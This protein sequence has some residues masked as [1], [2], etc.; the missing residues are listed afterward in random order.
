MVLVNQLRYSEIGSSLDPRFFDVLPVTCEACGS[1]Y[2]LNLAL[3]EL[4]CINPHCSD[5]V[6]MRIRKICEAFGIKFFG[7]S[8]IEKWVDAEE[9]VNP[10]KLFDVY[11]GKLLGGVSAKVSDKVVPQII[12]AKTMKLWEFLANAQLPYIQTSARAILDGYSSL[13]DF[14]DD[15]EAGGVD[16]IRVKLGIAEQYDGVGNPVVSVQATKVFTSL[17]DYKEEL[18][19][20]VAFVNIIDESGYNGQPIK[21]YIIV[22][23]D[24]VGEGFKTKRDFYNYVKQRYAE[25]ASFTIGSSVTKKTDIVIWKGFDGTPARKTSKVKRAFDLYEQGHPIQGYTAK[26]FI[27]NFDRTYGVN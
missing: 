16:F 13:S 14:Y 1:P 26:E 12:S 6:V 11:E 7:E 9:I 25:H 18:L 21:E 3:T 2:D 4:V 15:L 5:K 20:G 22:A 17:I 27:E 19:E 8:A 23:S 24:E 10:L